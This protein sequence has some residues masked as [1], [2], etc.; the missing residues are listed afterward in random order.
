MSLGTLL[1]GLDFYEIPLGRRE[2]L[3]MSLCPPSLLSLSSLDVH[4]Q[5]SRPA[6]LLWGATHLEPPRLSN[7][8]ESSLSPLLG[9]GGG[10]RAGS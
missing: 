5:V 10:L 7:Q 4:D 3:P 9:R 1:V 6:S 8:V 2:P